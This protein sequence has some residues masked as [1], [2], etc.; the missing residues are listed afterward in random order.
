MILDRSD[1]Q[2]YQIPKAIQLIRKNLQGKKNSCL[3]A[4]EDFILATEGLSKD[5]ERALNER[6]VG[7]IGSSESGLRVLNKFDNDDIR[8]ALIY[9]QDWELRNGLRDKEDPKRIIGI[10]EIPDALKKDGGDER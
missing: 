8:G 10:D 1:R 2:G 7:L 9:V 3:D 6:D 5:G 4:F